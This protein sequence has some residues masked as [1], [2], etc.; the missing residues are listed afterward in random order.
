MADQN[1]SNENGRAEGARPANHAFPAP[2]E[3]S[4]EH[5]LDPTARQL[6]LER[7]EI[8]LL[9]ITI[10]LVFVLSGALLYVK[11][12]GQFE[13]SSRQTTPFPAGPPGP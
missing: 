8:A 2:A 12:H 11:Y 3:S 1:Q 6:K 4:G 7:R 9:W 13:S 10:V 5:G